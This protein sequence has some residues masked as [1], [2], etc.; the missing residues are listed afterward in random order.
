[1]CSWVIRDNLMHGEDDDMWEEKGGNHLKHVPLHTSC[2][3]GF[4]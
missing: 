3:A 4:P 2:T 1:M